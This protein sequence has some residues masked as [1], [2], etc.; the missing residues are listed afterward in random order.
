MTKRHT[1][2]GRK[3][4]A[5]VV[6]ENPIGPH[7]RARCSGAVHA[8]HTSSRGAA[9]VRVV[10]SDRWLGLRS[11]LFL[12]STLLILGLELT[13]IVLEPVETLHPQTA[14]ALEPVV[15]LPQSRRF[16][17]AGPPLRLTAANDEA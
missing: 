8:A 17:A 10:M 11:R 16:N 5:R 4:N 13:Q 6:V 9:N 14:V 15:H 7:Q 12:S 1:P 2:P 3:S